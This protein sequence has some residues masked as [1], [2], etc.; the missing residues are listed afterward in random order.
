MAPL[1]IRDPTHASAVHPVV[2]VREPQFLVGYPDDPFFVY[3]HRIGLLRIAGSRWI[4]ATP[5]GDV[6]EEDMEGEEIIPLVARSPFPA[7]GRPFFGFGD[8]TDQELA[9]Y[10]TRASLLGEILGIAP[11]ALAAGAGARWVFSDPAHPD[12]GKEVGVAVL[13]QADKVATRDSLGMVLHDAE[14][15]D[16]PG[17][18][19]MQRVDTPDHDEWLREKREGAGRDPR[20]AS[21][22]SSEGKRPLFR[23]VV[24]SLS[25]RDAMAT[26]KDIFAGPSAF[27]EV[28]R[29]VVA[30]GLESMGYYAQF[31]A[32]SGASPQASPVIE[33]GHW[34]FALQALVCIDGLDAGQV[35]V[36]EHMC[37]RILM[38]QKGIARSP[39]SP[40]FSNLDTYME[41][42][43]DH[44]GVLRA[45][46]FDKHIGELDRSRAQVLKQNRLSSEEK[47]A[48]FK[49]NKNTPNPKAK[50]KGQKGGEE[51]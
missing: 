12:F 50:A 11:A 36:A 23:V 24:R 33:L 26:W 32:T 37:R 42:A 44:K 25:K 30:S 2:D 1:A 38:L 6:H 18:T 3:H 14:D 29:R 41:H 51:E 10:R 49:K 5:T 31:V 21:F 35:S 48:L 4:V 45:P 47:E 15:G 7:A 17:W 16:G 46:D 40:D 43:S 20:L 27:A 34:F 39:K 22:P 28:C 9:E 8:V 19:F 13:G